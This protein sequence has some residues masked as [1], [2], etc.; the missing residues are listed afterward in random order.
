MSDKRAGSQA[1]GGMLEG[2]GLS[3]VLTWMWFLGLG[4][5]A[6]TMSGNFMPSRM[7]NTGMLLPTM[8]KLPSRV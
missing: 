1:R 6:W 7:K 5:S 4:F 3:A 2:K 8:S